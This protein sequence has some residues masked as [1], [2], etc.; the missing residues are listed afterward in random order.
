MYQS[1]AAEQLHAGFFRDEISINSRG[2][3]SAGYQ[4]YEL[5]TAYQPIVQIGASG[6]RRVF[7]Y[8]GLVRCKNGKNYTPPPQF[9]KEVD[10]SDRFYVERLCQE[11]HIKNWANW[12]DNTGALFINLDIQLLDGERLDSK[13]IALA[14]SKAQLWGIDPELLVCEVIESKAHSLRALRYL[15]DCL[16]DFGVRIAVDDF[17][18]DYSN[19]ERVRLLKPDFVKLDGVFFHRFTVNGR[20]LPMLQGLVGRLQDQ[21]A[22]IIAEAVETEHHRDTALDCNISF[23]QGY[24]F[25]RPESPSD[26]MLR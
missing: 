13:N 26:K 22:E 14:V 11:M 17:G 18:V 9:F 20:L 12:S 10:K 25:G 4:G 23:M 8:E 3:Y 16:K 6:S 15:A 24:L 2:F 5:N 7:G 21:G 1:L 19:I